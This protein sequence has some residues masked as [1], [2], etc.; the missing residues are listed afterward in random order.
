M[1]AT[2]RWI[3]RGGGLALLLVAI[4][5]PWQQQYKHES[6]YRG[7][8]GHHLIWR[9]PQPRE[10]DN[11]PAEQFSVE[12][13]IGMLLTQ[14]AIVIAMTAIMVVHKRLVSADPKLLLISLLLALCL[15]VPPPDGIPVVAL[16]GFALA[17]PFMDTGHV[18]P[19]FMPVIAGGSLAIY[20]T[21]VYLF[22]NG[23][24]WLARRH[25]PTSSP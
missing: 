14:I 5:P 4:F 13:N 11:S 12:V 17:S 7:Q 21:I 24:A 16:I 8:I 1:T 20:S 9:Q 10:V 23:I 2:K 22:A 25:T 19:W 3:I 6:P 15:P 18:G